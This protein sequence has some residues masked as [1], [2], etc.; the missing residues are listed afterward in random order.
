MKKH[1][2]IPFGY[3][4]DDGR[5]AIDQQEAEIV[6]YIFCAYLS[7]KSCQAIAEELTELGIHYRDSADNWN[8][9]VLKRILDNHRY[10]GNDGYPELV[11]EDQFDRAAQL[12]TEKYTRKNITRPLAV[13]AIKSKIICYECGT[14]FNRLNDTRHPTKWYCLNRECQTDFK[15]TD[16]LLISGILAI[17]NEA[18]ADP[19][20]LDVSD[21][22]TF[23]NN[24]DI[25][26]LNNEINL[27]MEKRELDSTR[28]KAMIMECAAK[29]YECCQD[30]PAFF[31][32]EKLKSEFEN[33]SLLTDFDAEL[34]DR[35]VEAVLIEKNGMIH[36]RFKNSKEITHAM[37]E[38]VKM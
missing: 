21:N 3:Q 7:G 20:I 2:N 6:K 10:V 27:E 9:S 32:T 36:L 38:E 11:T 35:T 18:I 25:M 24:L 31:S 4:V 12:K 16:D 5:I 29:K 34:F 14:A 22:N 8:R 1:R 37:R 33:R 28:V 23:I 26:R 17:F 13:S 19:S 15:I 30:D